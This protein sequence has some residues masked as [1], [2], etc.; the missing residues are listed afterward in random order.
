MTD[1]NSSKAFCLQ[2][3][4]VAV[5]SRRYCREKNRTKMEQ[6]VHRLFIPDTSWSFDTSTLCAH[7]DTIAFITGTFPFSG[8][9]ADIGVVL[10][11]RFLGA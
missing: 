5:S 2:S 3:I 11:M 6:F 10:E 8:M 4:I 1:N 9:S 7:K